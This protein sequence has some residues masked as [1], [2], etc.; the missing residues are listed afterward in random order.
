LDEEGGPSAG[1]VLELEPMLDEYYRARGWEVETGL[2]THE[3]LVE[4]GLAEEYD[5]IGESECTS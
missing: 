3:K 5:L 4:L 2:P 1:S